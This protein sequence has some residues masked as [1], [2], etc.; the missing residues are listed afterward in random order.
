MTPATDNA[1]RLDAV[2]QMMIDNTDVI[3][4][5]K[6]THQV[7]LFGLSDHARAVNT[8]SELQ[9][10]GDATRLIAG[11]EE[12]AARFNREDLSAVIIASDGADNGALK[13][14]SKLPPAAEAAIERLGVPL[15]TLFS[16]PNDAPADIIVSDVAYDNFAFVRNAVSI[17]VSVKVTGFPAQSVPVVL[18]HSQQSGDASVWNRRCWASE[19]CRSIRRN[20]NTVLLSSSSLTKPENLSSP[21]KSSPHPERRSRSTTAATS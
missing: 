13:Q 17:E 8:V 1:S 7:D 12:V 16:G 6:G 9:A 18:K 21:S 14:G 20:P 2:K 11:L 19:H 3:S 5:W 4:R 15:H 10:R